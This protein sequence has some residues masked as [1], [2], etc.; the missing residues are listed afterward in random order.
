MHAMKYQLVLRWTAHSM[1]DFDVM[2]EVEDELLERLSA[3][4]AVDGHDAGSGEVNIFI[5]TDNP[6]IVFNELMTIIGHRDVWCGAR[7]AYRRSESDE[8]TVLWPEHL[9]AFRVR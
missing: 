1:K 7:V 5:R 6:H 3:E 4:T 9:Q 8:Y 2:I